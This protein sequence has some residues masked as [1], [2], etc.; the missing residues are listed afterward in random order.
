MIFFIATI[1]RLLLIYKSINNK[2]LLEDFIE[3]VSLLSRFY[4]GKDSLNSK[5]KEILQINSKNQN[6]LYMLMK[7]NLH[8]QT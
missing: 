1:T 6:Y 7:I 4:G 8:L 3:V 5:E 2:I